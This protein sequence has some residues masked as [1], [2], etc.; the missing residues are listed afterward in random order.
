MVESEAQGPNGS[1]DAEVSK[2]HF[3][4]GPDK[5]AMTVNEERVFMHSSGH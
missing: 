2:S 1:A 4:Q 5:N 3:P